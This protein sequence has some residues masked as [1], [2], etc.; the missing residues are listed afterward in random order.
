MST[1]SVHRVDILRMTG[2]KEP[3][4]KDPPRRAARPLSPSLA[5][6]GSALD[7]G[8]TTALADT[9]WGALPSC[10]PPNHASPRGY[11]LIPTHQ[12]NRLPYSLRAKPLLHVVQLQ[13]DASENATPT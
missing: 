7:V 1:Y 5:R 2:P 11:P 6:A 13:F 3:I 12:V 10:H 8:L 9:S 4:A